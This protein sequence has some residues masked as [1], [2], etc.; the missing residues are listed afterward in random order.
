MRFW[1]ATYAEWERHERRATRI[2][3]IAQVRLDTLLAADA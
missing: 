1:G 3:A 2:A